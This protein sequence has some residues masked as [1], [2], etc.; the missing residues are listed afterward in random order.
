[1]LT[2]KVALKESYNEADGTFVSSEYFTLELEHSLVS[3]SKWES[4]TE[5]PFLDKDNKTTEEILDYIKDMTL[6]P[7]VPDEV[8]KA[9]RDEHFRAINEYIGAKQTATWFSEPKNQP[10]ARREVVTAEIIY[11]W[12]VALQIDWQAQ[13]WHLNRL[14]TLIKVCN[15]KNEKPKKMSKGAA[16]RQHRALNE[17]RRRQYGTN[18]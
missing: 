9:L 11:Y 2:L 18:G 17:Q 8:F 16:I 13:Y 14:M 10:P 15:A 6:T 7:D 3:L 4:R 1:M 5:K 12:M